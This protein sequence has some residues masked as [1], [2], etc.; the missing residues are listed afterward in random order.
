[1]ARLL[2]PVTKM[3]SVI[4]AA[5]ASSTAYWIRGL[6]TT[7]SISFGMALVAGRKRVPIPATGKTA[8]R[9]TCMKTPGGS[10]GKFVEA[11]N[12]LPPLAIIVP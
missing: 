5:T 7:G 12:F 3:R 10:A 2:R 1:M 4:P 8:L 9:T 6:S 11:A